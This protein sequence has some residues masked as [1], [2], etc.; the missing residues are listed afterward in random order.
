MAIAASRR[1]RATEDPPVRRHDDVTGGKYCVG[2]TG[3]EESA[4]ESAKWSGE[5][6]EESASEEE[7]DTAGGVGMAGMTLRETEEGPEGSVAED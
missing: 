1:K 2:G 5:E 6:T 4:D 3:L 7:V